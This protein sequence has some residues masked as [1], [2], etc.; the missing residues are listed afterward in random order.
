MHCHL[1]MLKCGK[2]APSSSSSSSRLCQQLAANLRKACWLMLLAQCQEAL[3]SWV[4]CCISGRSQPPTSSHHLLMSVATAQQTCPCDT[5][6]VGHHR[7]ES[8]AMAHGKK[9]FGKLFRHFWKTDDQVGLAPATCQQPV[10]THPA[11]ANVVQLTA[12]TTWAADHPAVAPPAAPQPA[13]PAA[14]QLLQAS[15]KQG[16]KLPA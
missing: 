4:G 11:D 8:A 1:W 6:T 10:S 14:S 15:A 7:H 16:S 12:N 5:P 3:Q 9:R 2:D 13:Q